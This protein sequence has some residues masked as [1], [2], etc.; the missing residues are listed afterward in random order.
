MKKGPLYTILFMFVITA[1]FTGILA[2]ANQATLA[3]VEA[4]QQI[5]VLRSRLY[6]FDIPL[7]P[8]AE[9]EEVEDLYNTRVEERKMGALQVYVAMD[10][11]G[12]V[13]GYGIPFTG[14]GLWGTIEGFLA[15]SSDKTRILGIDFISHSETPGLGARIDEAPFKE[16]FRGAI[17]NKAG[18]P[19]GF[20]PNEP[21]GQVDAITGATVTSTSVE[22]MM[23]QAVGMFLEQGGGE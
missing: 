4:N 16:Q 10:E 22:N 17:L 14:P 20:R 13:R 7:P 6:A 3:R 15:L 12:R 9:D 18:K 8:S 1:V 21:E 2:Y 19:L 5:K 11:G 23:N